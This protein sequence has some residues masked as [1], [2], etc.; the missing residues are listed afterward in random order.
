[1]TVRRTI[2]TLLVLVIAAGVLSAVTP[3]VRA[4]TAANERVLLSLINHA[5]AARGLAPLHIQSALDKA[6]LAHSREMLSRDYFSHSSASGASFGTRL[7]RAGYTRSGWS[8]WAVSECIGWGKGL[9]G[10][11]QAIFR[12]WMNSSA[13]RPLLMGARWRDAGIGCATGTYKG[14]SG[15]LMYTVDLGRRIR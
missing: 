12:A 15:V 3:A 10:T 8:S 6:A 14:M 1:M 5:R 11:P 4:D 9:S 13:H 2:R 7:I